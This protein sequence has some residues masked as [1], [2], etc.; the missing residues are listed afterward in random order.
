MAHEPPQRPPA[1][2][3]VRVTVRLDPAT[4][5]LAQQAAGRAG[6]ALG[7]YLVRAIRTQAEG[8]ASPAP[9]GPGAPP[10]PAE[11]PH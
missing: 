3:A 10:A 2:H 4:H 6:L 7:A 11:G 5:A 1:R 9:A 8:D